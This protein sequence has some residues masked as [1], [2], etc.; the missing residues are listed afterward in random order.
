VNF[1][2]ARDSVGDRAAGFDAGA[3]DYMLKPFSYEELLARVRVLVRRPPS[4]TAGPLKAD[5]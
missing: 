4:P 3:D 2:T 5:A 1:L